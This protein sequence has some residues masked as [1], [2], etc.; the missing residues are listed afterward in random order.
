LRN[1]FAGV[2]RLLEFIAAN[3]GIIFTKLDQETGCI[4]KIFLAFITLSSLFSEG[5][6]Q[7]GE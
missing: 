6:C 4:I 3:S 1:T 5:G 2:G 7:N